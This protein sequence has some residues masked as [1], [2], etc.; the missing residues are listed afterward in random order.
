[1]AVYTALK[2]RQSEIAA[3]RRRLSCI[4]ITDLSRRAVLGRAGGIVGRPTHVELAAGA[5][6]EE[7]YSNKRQ[8]NLPHVVGHSAHE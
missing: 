8:Q 2:H 5:P 3:G 7:R 4:G 6:P 1:M